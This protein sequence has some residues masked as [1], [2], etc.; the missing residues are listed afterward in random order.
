MKSRPAFL[1]PIAIVLLSLGLPLA[2]VLAADDTTPPVGTLVVEG[3]ATYTSDKVV[4]LDVPATDDVGVTLVRV[5]IFGGAW[6]DYPYAP[7]IVYDFSAFSLA[8]QQL[9]FEVEWQ[10]AAGNSS[11]KQGTIWYDTTPPD[12][13]VF[14]TTN[15]AGPS[16]TVTFYVGALEEASGVAAVRFSTNGGSTWGSEIPMTDQIVVWDPRNAALGGEPTAFGSLTVKAQVRD[17]SGQ[18]SN[19]R[20]LV[21]P[22]ETTLDIGVSASPTT[23]QPVTLSAEWGSA[24]TLPAGTICMWEFMWGDNQSINYGNRNDTFGYLMTQGPS[25]QGYC[26]NWTFTLPWTPVRRYLVALHVRAADEM[27]LGDAMI[28]GELDQ[29]AFTSTVGSTSPSIKSSS[30]PAFYVLPD[31]YTLTVGVPAVYHAFALGGATIKTTDHWSIEYENVPER[32]PG[33]STLTFVPKHSGYLTVCLYREGKYQIAACYD[34]PVKARSAGSGS[35]GSSGSGSGTG[36]ASGGP[37]VEPAPS[38]SAAA[39]GSAEP[40][41]SGTGTPSEGPTTPSDVAVASPASTDPASP[42]SV[43]RDDGTGSGAG[44]AALAAFLV[45][46]GSGA[47]AVRNP[48]VRRRIQDLRGRARPS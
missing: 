35:G 38:A 22:I 27:Q 11:S 33:S 15:N 43:S 23:G 5:R 10:D 17:G 46:V 37:S 4:V 12:L 41:G 7:Q 47:W 25:S 8:Q 1:A 13:Q 18:W 36:T 39:S 16:G 26:T 32:H 29:T 24:I 45:L 31:A 2:Q 9:T 14:Q 40:S 21:L 20:S 42:S 28:G 19:I 3:G 48:D 6:T 44:L 34:P 30:L